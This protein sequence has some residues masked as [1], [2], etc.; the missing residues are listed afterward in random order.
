MGLLADDAGLAGSDTG[1]CTRILPIDPLPQRSSTGVIGYPA[2][3]SLYACLA[4]RIAR[5]TKKRRSSMSNGSGGVRWGAVICRVLGLVVFAAAFLLPG[6]KL[7][8]G[9]AD[10]VVFPGWKCA[11][12]ALSQSVSLFG[13]TTPGLPSFQAVLL[14]LSGWINILVPIV[15][16]LSFWRA[17]LMARRVIGGF[18]ILCMAATWTL[19]AMEKLTPMIGHVLWIV[20]ALLILAPDVLC[21]KMAP[22]D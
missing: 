22:R 8:G 10:S 1:I 7:N 2:V 20:G 13:K 19:L 15:L 4:G 21:A 11:S 12:I 3:F 18:I 14:T 17:L 5:E 16:L 9:S 6:V